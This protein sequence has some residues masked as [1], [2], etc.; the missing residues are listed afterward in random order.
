MNLQPIKEGQQAW[1]YSQSGPVRF[2]KPATAPIRNATAKGKY[3]EA[4]TAPVLRPGADDHKQ[5]KSHGF[6]C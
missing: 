6:G 5:F 4:M 2:D 3:T 1:G